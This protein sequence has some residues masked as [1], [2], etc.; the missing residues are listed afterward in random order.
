MSFLKIKKEKHAFQLSHD[1]RAFLSTN[2]LQK[3]KDG[4]LTVTLR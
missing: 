4:C 3:F 2:I 1:M